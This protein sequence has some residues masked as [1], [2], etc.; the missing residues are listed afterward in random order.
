[1]TTMLLALPGFMPIHLLDSEL[2]LWQLEW[3]RH[4]FCCTKRREKTIFQH[5]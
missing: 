3:D 2:L 4:A 5:L 1:M